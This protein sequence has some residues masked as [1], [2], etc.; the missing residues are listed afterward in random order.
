MEGRKR[1]VW[2]E[3]EE[4]GKGGG[5]EGRVEGRKRVE[6]RDKEEKGKE[7]KKE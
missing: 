5:K 6:W 4:K 2:R 3:K 7:G 1:V